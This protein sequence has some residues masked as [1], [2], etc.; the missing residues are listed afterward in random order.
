MLLGLV[1]CPLYS[2]PP[3]LLGIPHGRHW[4]KTRRLKVE[5]FL[6]QAPIPWQG[7]AAAGCFWGWER[8]LGASQH[9]ISAGAQ[10]WQL[11]YLLGDSGPSQGAF[12]L[13][14]GGDISSCKT[15]RVSRQVPAQGTSPASWSPGARMP[16]FSPLLISPTPL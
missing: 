15:A 7:L 9:H 8:R 11:W 13:G 4:W 3:F 6:P 16:S 14:C 5:R 12:S 2:L 10:S 1:V